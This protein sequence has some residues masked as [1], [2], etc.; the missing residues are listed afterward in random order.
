MFDACFYILSKYSANADK[1]PGTFIFCIHITEMMSL[2]PNDE[3]DTFSL[4]GKLQT[5]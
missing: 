3:A 2:N 5:K 4:G 1:L